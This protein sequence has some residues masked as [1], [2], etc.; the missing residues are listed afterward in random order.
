MLAP[1][2]AAK[3]IVPRFQPNYSLIGMIKIP[4]VLRAPVVIRAMNMKVAT[5]YHP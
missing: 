4:K 2:A 3:E 5:M 1:K